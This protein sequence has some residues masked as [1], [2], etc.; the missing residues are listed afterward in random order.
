MGV[1]NK[2]GQVKSKQDKSRQVLSDQVKSSQV[3][4]SQHR[5]SRIKTRQVRC[6]QDKWRQVRSIRFKWHLKRRF[7]LQKSYIQPQYIIL[8]IKN[9]ID[10]N[11]KRNNHSTIGGGTNF[12]LDIPWLPKRGKPILIVIINYSLK[13]ITRMIYIRNRKGI[14]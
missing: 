8:L 12:L 9:I 10:K 2:L 1:W 11:M 14:N 3:E 13:W 7:K 5:S 6:S 4:S